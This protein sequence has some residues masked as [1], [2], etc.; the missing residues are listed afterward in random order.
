MSSKQTTTEEAIEAY[1]AG[2]AS[3]FKDFIAFLERAGYSNE[4]ANDKLAEIIAEILLENFNDSNG[5]EVNP[6]T[7]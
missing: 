5:A 4:E 3:S 6:G 1:K 2:L 7:V